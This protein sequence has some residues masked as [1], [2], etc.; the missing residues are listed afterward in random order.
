MR[1]RKLT[2]QAMVRD[3]TRDGAKEPMGSKVHVVSRVLRMHAVHGA[4]LDLQQVKSRYR[5]L[6][7]SPWALGGSIYA[8]R[9]AFFRPLSNTKL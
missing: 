1:E 5:T 3:G 7:C 2:L 6:I 9:V 4:K 8:F